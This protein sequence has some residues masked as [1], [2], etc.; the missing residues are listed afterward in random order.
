MTDP[1]HAQ[2]SETAAAD[3]HA[4][5]LAQRYGAKPVRQRALSTRMWVLLAA[6]VTVVAGGV[7]GGG[8]EF[9]S[10]GVGAGA[11]SGL[12]SGLTSTLGPGFAAGAGARASCIFTIAVNTGLLPDSALA[13]EGAHLVFDSMQELSKALPILRTHWTLPV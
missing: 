2:A 8:G 12:G 5:T 3:S 6:C 9:V 7:C 13:D 10:P 4:D 11:G 1:S